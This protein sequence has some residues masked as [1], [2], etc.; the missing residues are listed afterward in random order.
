MMMSKC[1]VRLILAGILAVTALPVGPVGILAQATPPQTPSQQETQTPAPA[2]SAAAQTQS[3]AET[4]AGI[5]HL[6]PGTPFFFVIVEPVKTTSLTEVPFRTSTVG[7][8]E[9]VTKQFEKENRFRLVSP[10]EESAMV[11]F[12]LRYWKGGGFH[13]ET[14]FGF[15][16]PTAVYQANVE[17]LNGFRGTARVGAMLASAYWSS[18]KTSNLTKQVLV[19]LAT[20]D[21]VDA[22]RANPADLVKDFHRDMR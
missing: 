22:G 6:A 8:S 9:K 7:L 16:V 14:F 1:A 17:W 4:P 15:V 12:V 3:G 10:A 19:S 20:S 13:R 11:F 21:L 2:Q 18:Y 5:P